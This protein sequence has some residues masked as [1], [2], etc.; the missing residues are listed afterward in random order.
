[1]GVEQDMGWRDLTLKTGSA[2]GS[3]V[4]CKRTLWETWVEEGAGNHSIQGGTWGVSSDPVQKLLSGGCV[5]GRSCGEE[6]ETA[7]IMV[8]VLRDQ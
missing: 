5:M 8:L 6:C 1:M 3:D 2:V 4:G 7:R